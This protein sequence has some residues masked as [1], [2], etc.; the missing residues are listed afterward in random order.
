MF[1]RTEGKEE[2]YRRARLYEK[3]CCYFIFLTEKVIVIMI[4]EE[5]L[6]FCILTSLWAD[7]LQVLKSNNYIGT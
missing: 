3:A 6:F 7:P 4:Q 5:G 1:G 2:N